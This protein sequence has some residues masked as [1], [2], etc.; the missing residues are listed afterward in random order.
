MTPQPSTAQQLTRQPSI[1]QLNTRV[2]LYERG[3][4][5][6]RKATLDDVPDALID[7]IAAKGFQWVWFLGVW[8][9]GKMGREI[10]RSTPKL[11]EECRRVLPDLT[12][13]DITGSPFAI[14][15]YQAHEDFGGDR[16]LRN[17]RD[18]LARRRLKLLL[19]FVP[20]HTAPEHA[21]VRRHPDW[22]VHADAS[23][24]IASRLTSARSWPVSA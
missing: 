7:D 8:Q 6:G 10:S 14:T 18:R 1:Y 9:T 20:N 2:L 21:W 19:D 23:C 5:I 22:F 15:A 17:L 24:R 4:A 3:L 11:L 16:A 12:P 13:E